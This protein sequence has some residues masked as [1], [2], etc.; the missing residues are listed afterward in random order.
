[1]RVERVFPLKG[2]PVKV[3]AGLALL[4]GSVLLSM[5]VGAGELKGMKFADEIE[6]AGKKLVLNGMG[7]REGGVNRLKVYVAGLY[8][9]SKTKNHRRI[10][11]SKKVKRIELKFLINVR[12]DSIV[13][14]W[15]EGFEKH[16]GADYAKIKDRVNK[17]LTWMSTTDANQS[18]VFTYVPEK[19]LECVI[20]GKNMGILAGPDFAKI[21]FAI[22]LGSPPLDHK[23]R[24]HLRGSAE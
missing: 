8:L 14:A 4:L 22:W 5:G 1:M 7:I 23:L 12:E 11:R 20:K 13:T 24:S 3:F 10:L 16:A 19:G 15:K 21:F 18:Y 9:E 17:L 6:V 2:V